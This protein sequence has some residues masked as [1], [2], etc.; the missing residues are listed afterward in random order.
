MRSALLILVSISHILAAVS[1]WRAI[2]KNRIPNSID[3]ACVSILLY[4]D[5]GIWLEIAGTPPGNKYVGALME[6]NDRYFAVSIAI[7][8]FM[9]WL[10]KLGAMIANLGN[11]LE[12]LPR[13]NLSFIPRG[14][15]AFYWLALGI[16]VPLLV[17][18]LV[19][20][21]AGLPIWEA[22]MKVGAEW[23][24]F[25]TI[26][27]LPIHI[28][29]FYVCQRDARTRSGVFFGIWLVISAIISTL[30]I[31]ERTNMLVPIVIVVL[32]G[33]RPTFR[34]L[35]AGVVVLLLAAAVSLP[36]FKHRYSRAEVPASELFALTLQNDVSRISSLATVVQLSEPVGTQILPYPLAGYVYTGL[37]FIP[38]RF[39][40]FK[41]QST[42]TYFTGYVAGST[43]DET[44]WVLGIGIAEELL[45][46]AGIVFVGPGLILYGMG[47]GLIDR[48]T[49][50]V[51]SLVVPTRLAGLW[52]CGY[53]LPA[54][55]LT[56][57][58]MALVVW[59]LDRAF[60]QRSDPLEDWQ[61]QR[62]PEHLSI[63]AP[64]Y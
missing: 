46:N 37:F 38:R 7:L 34:S 5:V 29:A 30:A 8:L 14:R 2:S 21:S 49:R 16:T 20:V 33:I 55:L 3:F 26:L 40:P 44:D 31:G 1:F 58:T 53:N 42:A 22:R 48:Y 17:S 18:G 47:I 25:I 61:L 57:G 15:S 19:R 23:G 52:S 56:F 62:L 43:P 4:Y 12:P 36:L 63:P 50:R 45:L 27:Y 41:G 32:F 9:P 24:E 10:L 54:I 59:L 13:L 60:V 28:L 6:T 64:P 35:T 39:V 51:M 11:E